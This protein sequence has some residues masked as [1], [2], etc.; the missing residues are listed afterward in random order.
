MATVVLDDYSQLTTC[1]MDKCP[2]ILLRRWNLVKALEPICDRLIIDYPHNRKVWDAA[3]EP[4]VETCKKQD[5]MFYLE[6]QLYE[7]VSL[8]SF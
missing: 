4:V 7:L 6:T 1:L 3:L 2:D 8:A 5:Y